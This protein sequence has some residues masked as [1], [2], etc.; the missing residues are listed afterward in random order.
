MY[1]YGWVENSYWQYL[2][3]M[4]YFE[5]GLPIDPLTMTRRRKRIGD[6]GAEEPLKKTVETGLKMKAVNVSQLIRVNI[7]TTVQKKD[8]RLPADAQPY[9]HPREHLVKAA[10]I[11]GIPLHQ[12][13]NRKSKYLVHQQSCYAHARQMKRRGCTR[14]LKASL[15]RVI[16]DIERKQ[17]QPAE[18]RHSLL[19]TAKQIVAQERQDTNK[20]YSVHE[21]SVG[22]ISKGKAH[23]SYEFG[24]KVSVAATSRGGWFVAAMVTHGSLYD[25]HTLKDVLS[26]VDRI[27]GNPTHAFIDMGYRGHGYG[28]NVQI[29]VSKRRQGPTPRSL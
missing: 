13:Y 29:H 11:P 28:G 5:H 8:I 6:S 16:R 21:P 2:G 19:K 9:D 24:C 7:D 1:L 22:C 10:Q 15:E 23:K 12:H 17:P 4:K 27:A 14:K 20:V 18:H 26:Q 3:G 25:G